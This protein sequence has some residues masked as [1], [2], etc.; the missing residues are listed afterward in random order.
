M[1]QG[2][3]FAF[4]TPVIAMMKLPDYECPD[5]SNIEFCKT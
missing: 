2:P 1:M 3:S 4:V 5:K